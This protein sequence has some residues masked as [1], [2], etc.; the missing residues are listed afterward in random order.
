M[1]PKEFIQ[2]WF[3]NIDANRY[4]DLEKMLDTSHKFVNPMTPEP[5]G[6]EQHLGMIKMMTASFSENKHH[7]DVVLSDG[8]WVAARGRVTCKHTGEFNGVP[9]TNR[10]IEFSWIDVM[11]VVNGKLKEEYF[12]M[13]PMTIMQQ[14]S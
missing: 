10:K 5:A 12:E 7:L 2:I 11:H 14:V 6:K 1:T 3:A 13:N 8:E 4:E 9:P